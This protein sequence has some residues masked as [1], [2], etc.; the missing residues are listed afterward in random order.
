MN[1]LTTTQAA[2][3]LGLT[4]H[5]V[6]LLVVNGTLPATRVGRDYLIREADLAKAADRPGPGRPPGKPRKRK[7]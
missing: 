6:R 5:G 1:L 7:K 3:R 4:R 2:E